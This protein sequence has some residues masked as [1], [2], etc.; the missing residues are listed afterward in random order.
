MDYRV[1]LD[2]YKGPLD[3]LL[4]LIQENEVDIYDIPIAKITEQYIH[5]LELIKMLDPNIAGDFLVMASTLMEIKSRMLLPRPEGVE[6][7]EEEGD[8]RIDLIRQLM[9]YKKFKE[10]A[11]L[12][13]ERREEQMDR[14]GRGA[15]QRFEEDE[16]PR[17]ARELEEVSIW[18]LLAAF[19]RVMRQTLRLRPTTIV[20][21][22][23]PVKQHIESILR[24]LRVQGIITFLTIF[25]AC[26]DRI[27]AIG[28]LLALLEM[29]RSKV[30]AVEQTAEESEITVR[31]VGEANVPKLLAEVDEHP[32]SPGEV[33]AAAEVEEAE[34]SE[35]AGQEAPGAA[36]P[37]P[38]PA[39]GESASAKPGEE[40]EQDE[41]IE[42][43]RG[44][45][46]H[47]VELDEEPTDAHS[48]KEEPADHDAVDG[49]AAR[50]PEAEAASQEA[51]K[52][53]GVA[54]APE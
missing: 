42:S 24:M 4:Y 22:D 36:S 40:E 21:R 27:E 31:L 5:Y 45:E 46:I 16:E 54:G 44:I 23:V 28:A 9:E 53:G 49:E 33:K 48:A 3:L 13:A 26:E 11:A 34:V 52:E 51:R 10:A 29:V 32:V 47:E 39:R 14:F 12:L 15:P 8:P 20:D 7:E 18:D 30:V 25:E 17:E 6:V 19:D 37:E 1:T 35:E 41:E 38:A 2:I 43:I 50:E